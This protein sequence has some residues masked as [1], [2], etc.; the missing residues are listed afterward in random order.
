[1]AENLRVEDSNLLFFDIII[2]REYA[3][4]YFRSPEMISEIYVRNGQ[5]VSKGQKIARLDMFR[6]NN[7]LVQNDTRLQ[8]AQ[9]ELQDVLIGQG[10]DPDRLDE[11]PD[12]VLKLARLKSGFV[13]AETARTATL[14]DIEQGTLMAPHD[15]VV[16]NLDQKVNNMA[17][18][19][20]PFCRIINDRAMDIMFPVLESEL[21]VIHV[22]DA[23][24]V[25]PYS[26]GAR[27]SGHVTEI[28]PTVDDNG[29]VKVWASVDGGTG[30]IDGMNARVLA[31][32]AVPAQLV[33]P[34]SAVVLRSG[35]QVV[36]TLS[37]EGKAMWN[38]VH[39][40]LEN[41]E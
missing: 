2:A 34:K 16:A 40:G 30:L 28:N 37:P 24:E 21:A 41:M 35:R 31:H 33:V 15:G 26:G 3:D 32:R 38:Y 19:S 23:I 22:G 29:M 5:R 20:K 10:Y 1:M 6:L 4:L 17:S 7:Q 27:H 13:E 11:V 39:T 8:Q 14:K 25:A 9:I 18:S 12:D 36:F